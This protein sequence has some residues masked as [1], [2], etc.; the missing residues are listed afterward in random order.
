MRL[1]V[2]GGIDGVRRDGHRRD[3]LYGISAGLT[4]N[5]HSSLKFAYVG[6]R[7][8]EDLG[9]DTDNLALALSIRF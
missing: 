3:L 5:R 2:A 4:V 6:S 9:S 8:R 1:R 7:T